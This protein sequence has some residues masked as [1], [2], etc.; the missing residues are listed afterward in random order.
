[1]SSLTVT[2]KQQ[3]KLA[4]SIC[5]QAHKGQTDKGGNPYWIHPVAVCDK[6]TTPEEKIVALLHDVIED[7]SVTL[8]DLA[9]YGFDIDIILAVDAI[10]KREYESY[11][12][13]LYR[14][15]ANPIARVVKLADLWHN[16]QLD[17]LNREPTKKDLERVQKYEQSIKLLSENI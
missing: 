16:S 14:V 13:Y 1:M 9:T 17:R 2:R 6:C 3:I 12:K 8:T 10:T 5:L 11:E 15:K 7:T 4:Q